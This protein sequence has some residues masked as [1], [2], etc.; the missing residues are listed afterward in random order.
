MT[1]GE[2]IVP[3]G[4]KSADWDIAGTVGSIRVEVKMKQAEFTLLYKDH[5]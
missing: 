1:R 5:K 3:Y 2:K 4:D